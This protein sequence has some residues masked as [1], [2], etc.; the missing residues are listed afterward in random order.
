MLL[1]VLDF[2]FVVSGTVGETTRSSRGGEGMYEG[3]GGSSLIENVNT[4][5]NMALFTYMGGAGI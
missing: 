5:R 1:P 3:G 4:L 2:F